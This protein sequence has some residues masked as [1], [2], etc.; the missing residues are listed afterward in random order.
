MLDDTGRAGEQAIV[1][2]WTGDQDVSV[3]RDLNGRSML[4]EYRTPVRAG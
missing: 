2:A 1:A 4:L 3:L